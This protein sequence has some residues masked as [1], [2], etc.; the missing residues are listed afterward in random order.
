[1][2]K[3]LLVIIIIFINMQ[4]LNSQEIVRTFD[5]IKIYSRNS[6]MPS[7]IDENYCTTAYLR[8]DY[9]TK[10]VL[11]DKYVEGKVFCSPICRIFLSKQKDTLSIDVPPM[12]YSIVVIDFYMN[13]KITES[14]S[15]CKFNVFIRNEDRTKIFKLNYEMSQFLKNAFPYIFNGVLN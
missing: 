8:Q 12:L 14:I 13:N 2:K 7:F 3:R 5:S 10:V 4:Y 11:N 9:K 6:T 15:I 1:M